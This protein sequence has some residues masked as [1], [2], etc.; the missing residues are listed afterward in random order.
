MVG[1]TDGN[2]V[3]VAAV[4]KAPGSG[5]LPTPL[6]RLING[7]RANAPGARISRQCVLAAATLPEEGVYIDV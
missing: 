6:I 7:L 4:E 1:A 3:D 5:C 2:D